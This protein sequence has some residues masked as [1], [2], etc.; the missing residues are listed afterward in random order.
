MRNLFLYIILSVLTFSFSYESVKLI[1]KFFKN[2]IVSEL[3]ILDNNNDSDDDDESDEKVEC[4]KI[5]FDTFSIKTQKNI[6]VN[7]IHNFDMYSDTTVASDYFF[8][9]DFPPEV[10]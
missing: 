5:K 4:S 9:I 6:V 10:I 3:N 7:T 1:S 2:N 8:S